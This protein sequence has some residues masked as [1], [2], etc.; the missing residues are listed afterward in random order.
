[1][2]GAREKDDLRCAALAAANRDR[3]DLLPQLKELAELPEPVG[4][5]ARWA[6]DRLRE[7]TCNEQI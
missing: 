4:A 5:H 7:K 3:R 1:M 6:I 2:A